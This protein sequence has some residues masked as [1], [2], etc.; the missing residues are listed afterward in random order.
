[1]SRFRGP[2]GKIVRRFGVNIYGN[3]KFDRLLSR[4]PNKPGVHGNFK[5]RR[6][7]SEYG[8]QL[9]EKQKIK[10]TYGL[11]EREFRV[12]FNRAL[13]ANGITGDNLMILLE[14]RLDSVLY[15]LT[16]APS[17]DAARQLV[18][19]GHVKVNGRR[20]NIPSF[21][22]SGGDEISVKDSVRSQALVR[23]YLEENASRDVPDWLSVDRDNLKCKLERTPIR[24]ELESV[25]NEQLVVELFSK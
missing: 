12:L 7:I 2:K 22:I 5:G 10:Y 21:H 16:M 6:K 14:T 18:L 11:R 17:R 3:P 15:R 20:V 13:K 8:K 23:R 9:I 4:R 24:E 19:H 25:A 1:M